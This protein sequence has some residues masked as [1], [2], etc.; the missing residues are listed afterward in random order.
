MARLALLDEFDASTMEACVVK[1]VDSLLHVLPV[2]ILD[3]AVFLASIRPHVR[4][5]HVAS[6]ACEIL[7]ILPTGKRIQTLSNKAIIRPI[8]RPAG[9]W[10][11]TSALARTTG[12]LHDESGAIKLHTVQVSHSIICVTLIIVLHKSKSKLELAALNVSVL[13]EEMLNVALTSF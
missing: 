12:D 8:G 6:L 9:R 5:N 10:W 3:D 2:G 1:P 11:A 4:V 13:F 7:E